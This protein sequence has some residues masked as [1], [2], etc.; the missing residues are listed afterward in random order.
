[1]MMKMMVVVVVV[2]VVMMVTI[3]HYISLN[4]LLV[5]TYLPSRAECGVLPSSSKPPTCVDDPLLLLH[6]LF[7]S[8]IRSSSPTVWPCGS[9]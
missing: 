4:R 6:L 9:S 5:T 8:F 7:V 1:M 2:V 3:R